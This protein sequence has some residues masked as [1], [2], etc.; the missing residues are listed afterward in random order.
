M[1]IPLTKFT[2]TISCYETI[3]LNVTIIRGYETIALNV[4]FIIRGG[5]MAE[6]F[7]AL[8]LKSEGPWFKSSTL[9]PFAFVLSS[10]EFR[11]W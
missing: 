11:G 5:S 7:R 2:L 3:A 8:D 10:P 4:F 9:L 6:W 1:Y